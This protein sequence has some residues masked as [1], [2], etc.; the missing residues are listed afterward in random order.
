MLSTSSELPMM[1]RT[2]FDKSLDA[3]CGRV[4]F[5]RITINQSSMA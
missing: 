2:F 1:G 3:L 5:N 4:V